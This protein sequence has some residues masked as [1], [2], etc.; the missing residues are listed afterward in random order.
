M[1]W[2]LIQ[3]RAQATGESGIGIAIRARSPDRAVVPFAVPA[4]GADGE[5]VGAALAFLSLDRL[6]GQRQRCPWARA[7]PGAH[8]R[9]EWALADLAGPEPAALGRLGRQ[10]GLA[11]ALR[12]TPR[13][14][15]VESA[16]GGNVY[17]AA[18]PIAGG[19]VVEVQHPV[20]AVLAPVRLALFRSGLIAIGAFALAM[21]VG[22]IAARRIT[23]PLLALLRA[24]RSIRREEG[25]PRLPRSSTAE[26]AW[27]ADE[28]ELMRSALEPRTVEMRARWTPWPSIGCWPSAPP[29]S[30]V[31]RCTSA[32]SWRRTPLPSAHTATPGPS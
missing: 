18:I 2:P 26:V 27:L 5:I 17:A 20:E 9:P 15:R 16:T 25:R 24:L 23:E 32:R 30:S 4:R 12:G 6:E 14:G 7:G 8:R 10:P 21:L 31:H 1:S 28:L 13:D 11:D 3:T 29:T 22:M 19:W